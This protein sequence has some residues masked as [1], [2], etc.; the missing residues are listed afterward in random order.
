MKSNNLFILIFFKQGKHIFKATCVKI[1]QHII[2][3][4]YDKDTAFKEK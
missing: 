4:V 2:K 3:N 1:V